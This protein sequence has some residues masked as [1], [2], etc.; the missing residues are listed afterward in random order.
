MI[1]QIKY[2]TKNTAIYSIGQLAPKLVGLILLPFLTNPSYLSADDYGRLGLLEASST[3][4]IT[5]FGLGLNYALERWYWDSNYLDKRKSITFTL[6]VTIIGLTGAFWGIIALF[7]KNLSFLLVGKPDWIYL[8]NLLLICSALETLILIPTTLLRLEEKPVL[9]VTSN[10]V[11]FFFYLV[12]AVYFLVFRKNGLE[13][14][15]EARLFSLV[16]ILITLIPFI[17]RNISYQFEWKAL[18]EMI[19]FRLPLVLS[20][21]SYIIFTIT[22]RFSL[23]ILAKSSFKDVGVYNLGFTI[24]NS[25]KVVVIASIWLSVRPMIYKMMNEPTCKRFYSKLMKYMIFSITLFLLIISLFGQEAITLISSNSNFNKSFFIIP[26]IS[27]AIIFD[28]LKEIAQTVSLNIVKKT[29]VTGILMIFTTFINITLNLLLIPL[30]GIYGAAASIAISQIVFFICIYQYAQKYY[31]IPYEIGK[32]LTMILIYA[33]LIGIALLTSN[34]S[35]LVRIPI[36]MMI[37]CLFPVIL[38]WVHFFEEIEIVRL[39]EIWRKWRNPAEWARII[40]Q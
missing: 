10:L 36:K 34:L 33:I 23:R 22:D 17:G 35:L 26:I 32:V 38:Y 2:I 24:T 29:G 13:G 3:F 8:L 5:I 6:L 12:F 9:F 1:N 11:R 31:P 40:S 18:G 27:I 20:T 7:S 25:V 21:L 14:I 28:T 19:L 37:L 39:T 30:L 16:S 15:Y 4:L